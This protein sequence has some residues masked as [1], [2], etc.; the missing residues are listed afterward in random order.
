M[1]INRR[2][3]ISQL[4]RKHLKTLTVSR[5]IGKIF[6]ASV[7]KLLLKGDSTS[8]LIVLKNIYQTIPCFHRSGVGFQYCGQQISRDGGINPMKNGDIKDGPFFMLGVG[9]GRQSSFHRWNNMMQDSMWASMNAEKLGPSA[10]LIFFHLK[11]N[12]NL[13]PNIGDDNNWMKIMFWT[14]N[15][16]GFRLAR[17]T[18]GNVGFLGII[19]AAVFRIRCDCEEYGYTRDAGEEIGSRMWCC[20][21]KKKS[22]TWCWWRC[23]CLKQW[24]T[25]RNWNRE[26]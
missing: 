15:L 22:R 23:V 24:N 13:V 10:I 2:A 20:W 8:V 25:R 6:H 12:R 21:E 5:N 1:I 19:V 18:S 14:C 7:G 16:D 26:G 3:G 11:N 17:I 4:V 9:R